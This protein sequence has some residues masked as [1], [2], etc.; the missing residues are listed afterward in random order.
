MEFSQFTLLA[1]TLFSSL[2]VISY[3]PQIVKIACDKNGA[4]AISFVT[5]G[6]WLAAN[7]ATALYA[8][9]N[10]RDVYLATVSGAYA[11][12]CLVVI[13]LTLVKRHM[14]VH[15]DQRRHAM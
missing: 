11:L 12:S 10:L 6:M 14:R 9:V 3:V 5:W 1:F 13:L 15:R 8:A 4:T 7:L 2:R